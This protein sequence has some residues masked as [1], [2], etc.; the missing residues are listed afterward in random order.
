MKRVI[1]AIRLIKHSCLHYSLH[2]FTNKHFYNFWAWLKIWF[3]IEA[4][5]EP[6]SKA[7]ISE[8]NIKMIEDYDKLR[9]L[10]NVATVDLNSNSGRPNSLPMEN[11]DS[12][13]LEKW[14]SAQQNQNG[15]EATQ[16]NRVMNLLGLAEIL[17]WESFRD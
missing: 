15:K 13:E 14:L 5:L 9:L 10:M 11:L 8:Y 17:S 2:C 7:A 4:T 1:L 16:E 12:A 6:I 3:L